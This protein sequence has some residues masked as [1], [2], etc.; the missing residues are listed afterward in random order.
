MDQRFSDAALLLV[1]FQ[2]GMDDPGFPPRNNVLAESNAA[3]L[4]AAWRETGRRIIHVQ[5][6]ST[7]PA[8][9]FRPGLPGNAIKPALAPIDQEPLFQKKVS[10]A[11]VGTELERHLRDMAIDTLVVVGMQ[12]DQCVSTT[13]RMAANLGFRTY[14]VNDATATFDLTGPDGTH[15]PAQLVHDVTLASLHGEFATIVTTAEVLMESAAHHA[16]RAS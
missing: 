6:M 16:P 5:H 11:F 10:S 14:V 9:P 3:R 2:C 7:E 8:S 13:V 15:Y 12:T 4:L 1:D